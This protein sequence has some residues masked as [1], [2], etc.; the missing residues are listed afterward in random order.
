[1][2]R[3]LLA[4][5]LAACTPAAPAAAPLVDELGL[6]ALSREID[7]GAAGPIAAIVVSQGG[8]IVF[9]DLFDDTLPGE[10][11]DMRSAGKS[12]TALALGAA[13]AD[14]ALADLDAPVLSFFPGRLPPANDDPAK[15]AITLRDLA[16]MRSALQCD[17]WR[18]TPGTE[19]RMHPARDWTGF[20]IDLPVDPGWDGRGRFAYCTAGVFLLGQAIERAAGM[21]FDRYVQARI[22]DPIGVSGAT[23][24]GSR[25][26]EVQAGGQ[27]RLAARDAERLG[28]LVMNRG[29]WEGRQVLPAAWIDEMVT[30]VSALPFDTGYGML[31]WTMDL[32]A[33]AGRR[34]RAEMMIG[35]GGNVVAVLPGLDAVAVVQA[36][37]YGAARALDA[38]LG[39]I[40]RH[41]LPGLARAASADR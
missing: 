12:I 14:G 27:L 36:E 11:V 13:L 4:L 5:A 6:S 23:W 9:E 21:R 31:W 16:T 33:G 30:P 41:V 2:K 37:A 3:L 35:N 8:E 34:V 22:F 29:R 25:S 38:S 26:G 24:W 28:R 10:R 32:P 7:A 19:E 1:M 39:L 15:R 18:T 17:D 40:T 20:V